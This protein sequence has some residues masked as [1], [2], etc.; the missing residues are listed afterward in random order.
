MHCRD[1][2]TEATDIDYTRPA[3]Q[4]QA[5]LAAFLPAPP[6][7]APAGNTSAQPTPTP[8]FRRPSGPI[9]H[10]VSGLLACGNASINRWLDYKL[11]AMV[12]TPASI[13]ELACVPGIA[14]REL[15]PP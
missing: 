3:S 2:T 1:G 8:A 13:P 15:A 5:A 10:L 11:A 14:V 7:H 4:P 12:P 9:G 6:D